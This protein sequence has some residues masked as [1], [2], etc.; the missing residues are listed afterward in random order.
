MTYSSLQGLIYYAIPSLSH[1]LVLRVEQ[2][3]EPTQGKHYRSSLAAFIAQVLYGD[4][5]LEA[6]AST[7]QYMQP[8]RPSVLADTYAHT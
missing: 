2:N 5:M 6:D 7:L 1:N 3:L 4:Y 8:P